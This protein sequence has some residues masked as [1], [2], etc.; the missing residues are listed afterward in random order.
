MGVAAIPY[1]NCLAWVLEMFHMHTQDLGIRA[2]QGIYYWFKSRYK[3]CQTWGIAPHYPWSLG[4]VLGRGTQ[5]VMP[6]MYDA[7][8]GGG[9]AVPYVKVLSPWAGTFPYVYP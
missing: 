3:W 1:E 9:G 4:H 7:T 5:C 6:K 8:L 2:G